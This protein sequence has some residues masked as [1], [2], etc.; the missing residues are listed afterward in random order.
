MLV[1]F[2]FWSTPPLIVRSPF[3]RSEPVFV[4]PPIVT[5]PVLLIV[6][7]PVP[8]VK[9]PPLVVVPMAIVAVPLVAEPSVMVDAPVCVRAELVPWIVSVADLAGDVLT[10]PASD[11]RPS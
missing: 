11:C 5:V 3:T 4:P 1:A 8:V 9:V 2:D 10:G 7:S 6:N